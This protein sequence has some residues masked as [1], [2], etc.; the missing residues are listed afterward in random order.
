MTE[1]E[2]MALTISL[3]RK[4]MGTASPNPMVGAVL[5][6]GKQIIGQGYHKRAGLPHA[7]VEALKS[8]TDDPAGSTL[9]V[10][11]EPCVHTGR[12]PPCVDAVIRAG[13]KRVVVAMADPNP[14]VQGKGIAALEAAGITVK[15][16]VRE[17]EARELNEAF[18]VYMEKGR[19]FFIAKAAVSLDGKIAT[20]TYDAKWIS[21]EASRIQANKLR[22]TVDGILVGINTVVADNPF[23]VPRIQRPKKYPI[24]IILDSRLRIPLNSEIVKT[25]GKFRTIVFTTATTSP[26]KESKLQSLN[27]EVVRVPKETENGRVSLRHVS[28]EL[29]KR[30]LLSV[31]VEGGGEIHGG[32]LKE[33]L[34]DKIMLYYA[35]IIIGGRTAPHFVGGK[36][37]DFLKD[38]YRIDIT[39]VRRVKDDIF[40]EGYVHRN[41]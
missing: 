25:A 37:V 23:L 30:Q 28:S 6:K 18:I 40:V 27:V 15:T 26:D 29:Y 9:F 13:I 1:D 22:S 19:P 36:G 41:H 3:A 35:P 31:L 38:A 14:L 32:F 34:F 24:R 16:G 20:K 5:V 21:N 33:G 8:A 2:Y 7:E 12:T 17:K 11:L 4:G 10:N 39:K